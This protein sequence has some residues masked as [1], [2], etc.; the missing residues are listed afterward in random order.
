M[1]KM[2]A[3]LSLSVIAIYVMKTEG[4]EIKFGK[5]EWILKV[6]KT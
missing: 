1:L 3:Q 6:C 2:V 5:I 4:S